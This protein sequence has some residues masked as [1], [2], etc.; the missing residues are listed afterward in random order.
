MVLDGEGRDHV[1]EMAE[2]CS[3]VQTVRHSRPTRL[4]LARYC[5]L[6]ESYRVAKFANAEFTSAV[7]RTLDEGAFDFVWAHHLS[8]VKILPTPVEPPVILDQHN[9]DYWSSFEHGGFFE[10]LFARSNRR[11]LDSLRGHQRSH[12]D[13]ILSVSAADADLTRE[14]AGDVPVWVV[15]N[16]VDLS[17]FTPDAPASAAS[18]DVLFIGSLDR[19][20]NVE[21]VD[22]FG[23]HAWPAVRADHPSAT[24][25]VVGRRPTEAVEALSSKPGIVVEGEVPDVKPYYEGAAVVVAPFLL[26]GGTKLKCVEAMAM[27]RPLVTTPKGIAGIDAVDG[28]HALIRDR[29]DEFGRAVAGLLADPER[30]DEIA[31]AGRDLVRSNYSWEQIMADVTNRLTAEFL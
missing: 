16:G 11:R 4:A 17:E 29:D 20:R 10:S 5:L 25:T 30:R 27:A 6:G 1:N 24:F 15:P 12:V 2:L 19:R 26:G 7:E 22:W 14:W 3:E 9:A 23:E 28:T 31:T 21:A 13:L 18:D 8:T